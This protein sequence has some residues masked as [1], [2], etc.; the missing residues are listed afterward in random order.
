[1]SKRKGKNR[2]NTTTKIC[3]TC[4]ECTAIGEGD[5]ICLASDVPKM[6][7]DSYAPSD[8]YLWCGGRLWQG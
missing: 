5:H 4:N 1:M 3:E 2:T 8:E 7:L 6:V